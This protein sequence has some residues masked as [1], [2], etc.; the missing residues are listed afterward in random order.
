MNVLDLATTHGLQPQKVSGS[1]GGEFASRC[2]FCGGKDRFHIWPDQNS[3]SGSYW[4]RQCGAHGDR[5]QFVMDTQQI[6]F[7][8]ACNVTGDYKIA[9]EFKSDS[10]APYTPRVPIEKVHGYA[11]QQKPPAA[12]LSNLEIWSQKAEKLVKWSAENLP[13]SEGESLLARKGITMETAKA[14]GLGWIPKDIYRPRESWGLTTIIKEETGKPKRLWF[15]EGLVIPHVSPAHHTVDR[16]RIRR[17]AASDPRYYVIPGSGPAQMILTGPSRCVVIVESELDAILLGQ[18]AGDITTVISMGTSHA[19][20]DVLST[21]VLQEALCILIALDFDAA[22]KSS[23]RWWKEAF[24]RS[25]RWPVPAGKDP[26]DAHSDGVDLRAWVVAGW[27]V[28]WR[29]MATTE[30]QQIKKE[31]AP[32][33]IQNGNPQT[34]MEETGQA[35]GQESGNGDSIHELLGL[36]KKNPRIKII[37]NNFRLSL[38]APQ[39]WQKRNEATF[40]KISRL[41]Y[42]DPDVFAHIHGRNIGTITCDNLL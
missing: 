23:H 40:G 17:Q 8:A 12:G 19:K 36:L 6:G 39:D 35:T 18:V 13:G 21:S 28:G 26:S 41:V 2:P 24:P 42:F 1:K 3:G 15:P 5:I 10:E 7:K 32:K 37:I 20:P 31:S 11:P 34:S 14:H 4:C 27:P 22:G 30:R 16:L 38:Q 9:A 25:V 33:Q 29:I